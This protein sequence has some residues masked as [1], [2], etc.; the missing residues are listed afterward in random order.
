MAKKARNNHPRGIGRP[1]AVIDWN[2]VNDL[3]I[4]GCSGIEIA[5]YLGL[6]DCTIY[7]RCLEDNKIPF[8]EYSQ[9]YYAKGNTLLRAKQF[10]KAIDGENMML[11][12]LG[13]NRLKQSNNP[14]Q[15]AFNEQAL[16][17]FTAVMQQL[18]NLQTSSARKIDDI[19]NNS[20]EK[21]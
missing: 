19:S 17:R 20:E 9:R 13:K 4:A 18:N 1:K 14:T 11:I 12:W 8:S 5:G 2:K 15:D 3:L 10:K 6:E 21:S 7:S 16:D